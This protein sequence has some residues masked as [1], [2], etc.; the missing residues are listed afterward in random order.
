MTREVKRE[1]Q[2]TSL[3]KKRSDSRSANLERLKE[4]T[5][6]PSRISVV[7]G[8]TEGSWLILTEFGERRFRVRR[9]IFLSLM[10]E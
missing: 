2:S 1:K 9:F 8:L 6:Y 7:D 5:G 10:F 4:A 3:G